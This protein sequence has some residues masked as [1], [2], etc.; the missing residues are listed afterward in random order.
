MKLSSI[1][2]NN[3][4]VNIRSGWAL[5]AVCFLDA[6]HPIAGYYLRASPARRQ[7]IHAVLARQEWLLAANNDDDLPAQPHLINFVQTLMSN[8]DQA[9]LTEAFT[10][11]PPGLR[12]ALAKVGH[13]AEHRDF[14]SDLASVFAEPAKASIARALRHLTDINSQILT[15]AQ[16]LPSEWRFP[17]LIAKIRTPGECR[18][19]LQAISLIRRHCPAASDDELRIT[20]RRLSRGGE[21]ESFVAGWLMRAVFSGPPIESDIMVPLRTGQSLR[22][23]ARSMRNCLREQL[24]EIMAGTSTF[25]LLK[26]LE[27]DVVAHL[28]RATANDEWVLEDVYGPRNLPLPSMVIDRA[29][30]ILKKHG[31]DPDRRITNV[32]SDVEAVRSYLWSA[33]F[34]RRRAA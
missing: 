21:I 11:C 24:A 20:I 29:Y 13:H 8:S 6:I 1:P 14:Y 30:G 27:V 3:R 5:N 2:F 18:N 9:L 12:G 16:T 7:V 28:H 17:G 19:F 26:G 31:I 34:R 33:Q 10:A 22:D 15:V 25:F 32:T 23:V 4:E